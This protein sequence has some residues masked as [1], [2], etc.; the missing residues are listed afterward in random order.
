MT[1]HCIIGNSHV[2]PIKAAWER[3]RTNHPA[4]S[5]TFLAAGGSNLDSLAHVAGRLQPTSEAVADIIRLTSD[6]LDSVTLSEYDTIWCVGRHLAI[7]SVSAMYQSVRSETS[8]NIS[9]KHIVVSEQC[10][11]DVARSALRQTPTVLTARS[12]AEAGHDVHLLPAPMPASSLSE[13]ELHWRQLFDQSASTE[14]ALI[15]NHALEGAAAGTDISTHQQPSTTLETATLT[16]GP[17]ARNSVQFGRHHDPALIDHMHMN[18][19]YGKIVLDEYF[20]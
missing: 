11:V 7:S 2:A 14:L 5:I 20:L 1:R 13:K 9:P 18:E 16:K 19:Q 3:V 12:I 8:G 10:Y 17:F 6:G 15:F 4:I